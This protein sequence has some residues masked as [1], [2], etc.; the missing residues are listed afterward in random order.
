MKV[1]YVEDDP[2]AREFIHNPELACF[3]Y[4][5][6]LGFVLCLFVTIPYC[7]FA[8]FVYR[9]LAMTHERMVGSE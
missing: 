4:L 8:H 2:T 3:A 9:T 1:L 7:K 5:I 6:H